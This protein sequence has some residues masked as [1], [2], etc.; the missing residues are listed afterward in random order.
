LAFLSPKNR[1]KQE[2]K[3]LAYNGLLA[4]DGKIEIKEYL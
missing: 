1:S 4:L 3:A 2:I